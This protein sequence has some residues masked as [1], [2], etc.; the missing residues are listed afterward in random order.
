M[1]IK[2]RVHPDST[3]N[4]VTKKADDHYEVIEAPV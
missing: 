2:I 4:S 3:R 1:L